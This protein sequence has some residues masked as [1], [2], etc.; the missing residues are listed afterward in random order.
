MLA[1]R[2]RGFL[3]L[4]KNDLYFGGDKIERAQF[5]RRAK[6]LASVLKDHGVGPDD[7]V[8][9]LLRNDTLY[10]EVMQACLK[11]VSYTHLTLPTNREV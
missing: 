11:A 4:M 2:C 7:A 10:L 1:M 5:E 8:A 9:V 6:C 3:N